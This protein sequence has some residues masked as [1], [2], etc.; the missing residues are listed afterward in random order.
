M[1]NVQKT[2]QPHKKSAKKQRTSS[3]SS[4]RVTNWKD[5]NAALERRGSVTL[6]FSEE[7]VKDW[8]H[9]HQTNE[10]KRGAQVVYS[11]TAILLCLTLKAVYRL[12]YRQSQGFVR[13]LTSLLK[14]DV[15]IPDYTT[16]NRRAKTVEVPLA[17]GKCT[18]DI[19]IVVDSTGLKVYGE[20]EW[21][22][23]Q[24]GISKRRTW[25]KL[26]LG[27]DEASNI[28]LSA[29]ITTNA[30]DDAEMLAPLLATAKES[31][32]P[33]GI[34]QCSGDGAYDKMKCYDALEGIR[35]TIPPRKDAK[36]HR[37]GNCKAVPKHPRD[38]NLRAIRKQGRKAWKKGRGYH[39]RSKAEVAMFRYKTI[40][41]G[42]MNAREME[43]QK[44][45]G[46]IKC[47]ILNLM[48][49]NGMPKSVPTVRKAA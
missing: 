40:F 23:R 39:R 14:I 38:E 33:G 10:R 17:T 11:D 34:T 29:A 44:R 16:M 22:V 30:I 35:A 32:L 4:Y 5:Y 41:G 1:A 20:G 6:W 27:V 26:H 19:H 2:A 7:L 13:S 18:G 21:K 8:Y 48:T 9:Q 12:P 49:H 3:G 45:E 42:T 25:R 47:R 15:S 46:Q 31:C 43:R 37:H 28:I 24:H 36:I